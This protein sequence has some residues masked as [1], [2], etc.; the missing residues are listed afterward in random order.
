LVTELLRI[1]PSPDDLLA[2]EPEEL[3][4]VLMEIIPSVSQSAGFLFGA[5]VQQVQLL[6][7]SGYS[8]HRESE[9]ML[10]FAEAL[11]WLRYNGL[12]VRNP[13]QSAEWFL[14]TRRGQQLRTRADVEAFAKASTLPIRLLQPRLLQKVRHL[15][16]RGDWDVAVVQAFKEVEVSVRSACG[17]GDDEHGVQMMRKAFHTTMGPLT[18][19]SLVVPER[20]A[21]L[22]LFAG[23]IGHA[24]NP[25]SHREVEMGRE[26]AARLIVFA[27]H[28]LD[29]VEAR[30]AIR[31]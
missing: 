24:K 12:I 26:T 5:L 1:L 6:D 30:A 22:A 3:A 28:L 4:G 25:G 8:R 14:V 9:V 10:A 2:L 27:S 16:A 18:D 17:W 19:K 31:S 13:G 7:G 11:E 23:A 21:E 29:I 20:E 15:F